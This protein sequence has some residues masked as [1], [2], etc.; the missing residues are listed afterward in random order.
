VTVLELRLEEG[1][2]QAGRQ[3]VR[4]R[5]VVPGVHFTNQFFDEKLRLLVNI[6]FA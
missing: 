2:P 6:G 1:G 4:Q 5:D 3:A